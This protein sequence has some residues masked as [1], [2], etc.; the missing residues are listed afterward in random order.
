MTIKFDPNA[1]AFGER[2]EKL[3]ESVEETKLA[4]EPKEEVIEKEEEIVK[5]DEENKVPYSRFK[6]FN[7]GYKQSQQEIARLNA[8]LEELESSKTNRLSDELPEYW[9]ELYGDTDASKRAFKIQSEKETELRQQIRDEALQSVREERTREESRLNENIESIDENFESLEESL[10]RPLTEKEQSSLL[11]I[12]DEFTPTGEDGKYL[13]AV[14]SFDK[15]W[16]IY[17]MK[18]QSSKL[19]TKQSRD[20]VASLTGSKSSGEPSADEIERDKNFD[21]LDKSAWK[22]RLNN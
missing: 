5:S 1:P 19:V 22:R 3:V 14:M 16:Q 10:K 6:K 8:R 18:N 11:D 9:K 21:P 13:G 2:A 17:E 7:E 12:I 20:N 15:A 4:P